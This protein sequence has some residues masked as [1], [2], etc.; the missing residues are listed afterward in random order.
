MLKVERVG[1]ND[2]IPPTNRRQF[3][4][5]AHA[6]TAR[7]TQEDLTSD[8]CLTTRSRGGPDASG[9]GVI[10]AIKRRRAPGAAGIRSAWACSS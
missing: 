10:T 1:G 3:P 9:D 6:G 7:Q 2:A 8:V 5:Q 4:L